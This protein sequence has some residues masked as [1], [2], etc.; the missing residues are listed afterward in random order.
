[1]FPRCI[2]TTLRNKTKLPFGDEIKNIRVVRN[3]KLKFDDEFKNIRIFYRI[4]K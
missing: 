1:M 2:K 3:A 4:F